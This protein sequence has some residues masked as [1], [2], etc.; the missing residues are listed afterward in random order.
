MEITKATAG[1]APGWSPA[2]VTHEVGARPNERVASDRA[3][4]AR[5]VTSARSTDRLAAWGMAAIMLLLAYEWLL[6][7][8]DKLL[9]PDFRSGLA[10]ELR[11]S[12]ADNPDHWYVRLLNA[13]LISHARA[14][15]FAVEWGE[16]FV[17]LGLAL[18]AVLWIGGDRISLA[19]SRRLHLIVIVALLGG[20][21]MTAN[22]YFLAGNKLPW[23]NSGAP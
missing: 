16:I 6:S 22:Y 7:A 17:A 19:W 5:R 21:F 23:V 12:I 11:E 1:P 10:A 13:G 15:A 2:S 18:G 3:T 14:F 4:G 9:S 20:A 8:L